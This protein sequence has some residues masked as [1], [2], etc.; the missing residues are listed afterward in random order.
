L[1][2]PSDPHNPELAAK[3]I[4]SITPIVKGQ[5]VSHQF[6]IPP[7][8]PSRQKRQTQGNDNSLIDFGEEETTPAQK[9]DANPSAPSQDLLDLSDDD[10]Q[11]ASNNG[12]SGL[13][14]PL[15]PSSSEQAGHPVQ[16]KDSR[17]EDVEEFVDAAG[18]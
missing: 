11:K 4:L 9:Q 5:K 2:V 18:K 16:R 6:D 17:T 14:P 8:S 13:M 12:S 3:Q 15:Q 7:H 1:A 10:T